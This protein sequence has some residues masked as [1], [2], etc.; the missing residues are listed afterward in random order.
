MKALNLTIQMLKIHV[1]VAKAS[2]FNV[3]LKSKLFFELFGLNIEVSIELEELNERYL[4]L[5]SKFHPDKFINSSNMEKSHATTNSTYI[6]DAYNTLKIS[7]Y[8]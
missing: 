6:N 3:Y 7:Y 1:A 5:Q 8:V 2:M 4:A